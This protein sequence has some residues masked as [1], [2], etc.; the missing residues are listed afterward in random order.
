MSSAASLKAQVEEVLSR[1]VLQ[2]E[3]GCG[4]SKC[5]VN[6]MGMDDLE[7][8]RV[9]PVG[10]AATYLRAFPPVSVDRN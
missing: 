2:L 7:M 4:P 3:L 1:S 10:D 8:P 5:N 6:A 9:D